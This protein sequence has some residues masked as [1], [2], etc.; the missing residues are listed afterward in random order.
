M[1]FDVIA[2]PAYE[3]DSYVDRMDR[4]DR[5]ETNTVPH[6]KM[7]VVAAEQPTPQSGSQHQYLSLLQVVSVSKFQ[8]LIWMLL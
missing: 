3:A 6:L 5:M 8:T 4:I 2:I 7:P 1:F